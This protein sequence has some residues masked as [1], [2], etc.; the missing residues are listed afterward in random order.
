MC[1]G[2]RERLWR[3]AQPLIEGLDLTFQGSE[4]T[5]LNELTPFHGHEAGCDAFPPVVDGLPGYP[6]ARRTA[7]QW[8]GMRR[9]RMRHQTSD[10]KNP[11][12]AGLSWA[13]GCGGPGRWWRW[14]ESNPRPKAID[15]QYYMLSSPI[16]LVFRQYGVLNAPV[17]Q[18]EKFRLSPSDGGCRLSRDNDGTSTST[19]TS[20]FPAYALSGE[21]VVVVVGN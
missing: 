15:A 5:N 14:R 16:D 6:F 12:I 8:Q 7:D 20:G 11:A 4:S 9:R 1:C 19:S 3:S 18:S 17:D 10:T 13:L 2:Y 21:S